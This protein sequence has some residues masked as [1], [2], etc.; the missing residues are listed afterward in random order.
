MSIKHWPP[1]DVIHYV[2]EIPISFDQCISIVSGTTAPIFDFGI[3]MIN[4]RIA[5]RWEEKWQT[6][7]KCVMNAGIFTRDLVRTLAI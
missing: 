2:E 4:C 1:I 7:E 3:V 6:L 5:S